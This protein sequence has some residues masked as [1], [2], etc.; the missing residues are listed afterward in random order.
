MVV[1]SLIE[2]GIA[3]TAA[4]L[5]TF[6]SLFRGSFLESMLGSIRSALS[7]HSVGKAFKR[8]RD[9]GE[10]LEL[11]DNTEINI[12]E[13]SGIKITD[14]MYLVT[15]ADRNSL[16][17]LLGNFLVGN[18]EIAHA[19]DSSNWML[20]YNQPESEDARQK[21][22]FEYES[23]GETSA[24]LELGPNSPATSKYPSVREAERG[25]NQGRALPEFYL[26]WSFFEGDL[27][28]NRVKELLPVTMREK[29]MMPRLE[30]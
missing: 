6:R 19:F 30:P 9:N 3:I 20:N 14:G 2:V 28:E 10:N 29:E 26:F 13:E 7:L 25:W 17:T 4:C 21:W 27:D 22:K 23:L 1:W 16:Q 18:P 5:P 24:K 11:T 8:Q 12:V 15:L